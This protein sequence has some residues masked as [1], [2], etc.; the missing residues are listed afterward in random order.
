MRLRPRSQGSFPDLFGRVAG[1]VLAGS[2]VLA[3]LLGG[4]A[5]ARPALLARLVEV[6]HDADDAVHLVARRLTSTFGPPF[7]RRD[8]QHLAQSLDT[9]LDEITATA[10]LVVVHRLETLPREVVDV[11]QVLVRQAELTVAAMPRVEQADRLAEYWVEVNRL[12]NRASE[13]LLGLRATTLDLAEQSG[14]LVRALRLRDVVERLEAAT[15]A[16]ERL[17]H[18]VETIALVEP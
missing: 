1:S 10:R 2:Q 15:A 5:A 3:E 6:E 11:A 14:D 9:C 8:V 7:A 12:D 17:A 4:P 18:V 16:F 13:V